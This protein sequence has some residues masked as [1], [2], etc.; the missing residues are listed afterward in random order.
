VLEFRG[1]LYGLGN[2]FAAYLNE[3][4]PPKEIVGIHCEQEQRLDPLKL[5][6]RDDSLQQAGPYA[7]PSMFFSDRQGAQQG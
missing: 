3:A 1:L 6:V 2:I 5:R 4:M 7:P